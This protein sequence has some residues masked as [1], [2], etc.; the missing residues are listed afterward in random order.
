MLSIDADERATPALAAEISRVLAIPTRPLRRG[1]RV[2]IRSVILGRRFAY[3]GTQHDL[4]LRLFR[5]DCGPVVGL[6]HETVELDGPAGTLEH[7][8][9]HHTLPNVQVFLNKLDHY[10]TLEARG[11]RARRGG[12]GRA[13]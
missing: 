2:P 9:G 7:A 5:R 11:W 1:F 4:P 13:T 8:L 12:S 10:T 3:S 6:V